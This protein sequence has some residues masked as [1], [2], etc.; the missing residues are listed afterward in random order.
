MNGRMDMLGAVPLTR[1]GG[2]AAVVSIVPQ[3]PV[4]K[5][6]EQRQFSVV[7]R[8]K[9]GKVFTP[10]VVA[11]SVDASG[12]GTIDPNGLFSALYPGSIVVSAKVGLLSGSTTVSI[13]PAESDA[14]SLDDAEGDEEYPEAETKDDLKYPRQGFPSFHGSVMEIDPQPRI[15]RHMFDHYPDMYDLEHRPWGVDW[16]EDAALRWAGFTAEMEAEDEQGIDFVGGGGGHHGGH[17]HGGGGFRGGGFRGGG[18]PWYGGPW[19]DVVEIPDD[20]LDDIDADTIAD[21]VAEK[22][23]RKVAKKAK[24]KDDDDAVGAELPSSDDLDQRWLRAVAAHSKQY[25]DMSAGW[26][27]VVLPGG[28][29]WVTAAQ[30]TFDKAKAMYAEGFAAKD[31]KKRLAAIELLEKLAGAI[32]DYAGHLQ[33]GPSTGNKPWFS[34]PEIP[35]WVKVG[36]VVVLLGAAGVG[37]VSLFMPLLIARA[38]AGGR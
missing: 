25:E 32:N 14:P 10:P 13:M 22:L 1:R 9:D 5:V 18:F 8:D 6:G 27:R 21:L 3:T 4:L 23:A 16:P 35:T 37:V 7:V 15:R 19:Y 36:G 12:V 20:P 34:W 30:N 17:H 31:D 28:D 38:S 11:W 33:T 29:A 26:R 24:K 2:A